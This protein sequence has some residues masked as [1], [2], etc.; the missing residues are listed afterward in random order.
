MSRTGMEGGSSKKV[1][2]A[3]APDDTFGIAEHVASEAVA[4]LV[5]PDAADILIWSAPYAASELREQLEHSPSRLV[6]VTSAG[7][8]RF[9]E[10][11]CLDGSRTWTSARGLYGEACAEHVLALI[12]A[13]LRRI[14]VHARAR[15]NR[16]S[17]GFTAQERLLSAARV[18]IVGTGGIGSASARLLRAFGASVIGVNRS[19]RNVEQF[20]QVVAADRMTEFLGDADLV[21]L[22]APL[23]PETAGLFDAGMFARMRDGAW[24]INVARGAL[25]DTD[26][27]VRALDRGKLAG[28]CL[29]V[30][31]PGVLP[32]DHPLWDIDSVLVTPHVAATWS[33]SRDLLIGRCVRNVRQFGCNGSLEG[34]VDQV[35]AY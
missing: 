10:A 5:E 8:E 19:G 28:A 7:V 22:C 1:Q 17:P 2:V 34:V 29:D 23:T 4:E 27:L 20:D 16:V 9:H 13:A 3:I 30:T 21:V 25:V 6:Q 31:S 32:A 18:L 33:M 11:G 26:A 35:N 14:H 12:L 24:L 15:D